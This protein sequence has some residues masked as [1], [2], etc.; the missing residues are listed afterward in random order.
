MTMSDDEK[1]YMQYKKD[2]ISHEYPPLTFREWLAEGGL[3]FFESK[4]ISEMYQNMK[5]RQWAQQSGW[6]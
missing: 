1:K 6:I 2:C 3:S 5:D 4:R